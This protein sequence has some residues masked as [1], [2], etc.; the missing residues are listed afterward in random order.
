[1]RGQPLAISGMFATDM[2]VGAV[3]SRSVPKTTT[4]TKKTATA[5]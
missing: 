3:P 2:A 4:I 5:V 1:M